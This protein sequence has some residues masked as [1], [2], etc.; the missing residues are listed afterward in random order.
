MHA[1]KARLPDRQTA[2]AEPAQLVG[3]R[4]Q[5]RQSGALAGLL[6]C[7]VLVAGLGS[8]PVLSQTAEPG[9]HQQPAGSA[10]SAGAE[11]WQAT[12]AAAA[13][14]RVYFHTWGGSTQ[15]NRYLRWAAREL[16]QRYDID[17]QQ[18]RVGDIS[19]SVT[20][21]LNEQ[22]SGSERSAV[23]LIWL[24]GENFHALKEAELL[25]GELSERVPNAALIHPELPHEYDFGIATDDHELP[26]GIA[27]FH[28]LADTER[29]PRVAETDQLNPT[30][31]LQLAAD[32]P[33]EISYPRPPDFHGTT[34]LKQ[35]ALALSDDRGAFTQPADSQDV[36]ATLAPLWEY[37]DQLHPL[38]W[39]DGQAFMGSAAEQQQYLTDE[40]LRLALSFNPGELPAGQLRR[41]FTDT[42]TTV[43][44]GD[45][46]ITNTHNLAIPKYSE[47][48]AAAL[49]T[50]NFLLSEEAQKRK[51]DP[52]HWGDPPVMQTPAQQ[53]LA[54]PFPVWE[55]P[56]VS[57]HQTIQQAWRERYE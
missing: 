46:A 28:L 32:Y 26:W 54:V 27:Q 49:V 43:L 56:H 21:L 44:L 12:V 31:L 6:L 57:W 35:L 45:G 39:R 37:L 4:P 3:E 25:L 42:T 30:Q 13:G 55:E 8:M 16:Q 29:L 47:A 19:E 40:R 51:A 10:P 41:Q 17:L 48:R 2:G 1:T 9:L 33:G 38:L 23:D 22:R 7:L 5:V 11:A 18:V 15:V 24:N 52:E 14:Q 20:R 36:A 50:L 53:E 34:F